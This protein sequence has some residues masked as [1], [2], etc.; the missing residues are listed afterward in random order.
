M[1]TYAADIRF[2]VGE[3]AN[4]IDPLLKGSQKKA[5]ASP[6]LEAIFTFPEKKFSPD[7]MIT[8]DADGN[9]EADMTFPDG[10]K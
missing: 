7:K 5:L 1:S 10:W 9:P 8:F 4:D 2:I 3:I 6:L